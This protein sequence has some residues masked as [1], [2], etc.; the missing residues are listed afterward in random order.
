MKA[1]EL[2]PKKYIGTKTLYATPITLG[3]YNI[4]RGW[5]IPENEDPNEIG[6][7]C[8]DEDGRQTYLP[9]KTFE[10][11]YHCIE[12]LK[13][14]EYSIVFPS[15]EST[16]CVIPDVDYNGAHRYCFK[17]SI[18][19]KDGKTEYVESIQFIQ[20]VQKNEDGSMI[21]GIQSEQLVLALL[22]RTEKLNNRYPS[23]YNQRMMDALEDFLG[24]CH[25]R[26]QDRINRGVMGELKK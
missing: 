2:L 19:F 17:N 14:I 7:L 3:T 22:D 21:P 4:V 18:G 13:N 5:T 24:A 12:G 15:E 25:D 8:A 6:Y 26:I 11:A 9:K 20:F 16:I 23:E 10:D 1:E